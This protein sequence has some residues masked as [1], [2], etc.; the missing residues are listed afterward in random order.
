MPWPH[1]IE[2][3]LLLLLAFCLG[4]LLTQSLRRWLRSRARPAPLPVPAAASSTA[5]QVLLT[6]E[7]PAAPGD[8]KDA[9]AQT[10]EAPSSISSVS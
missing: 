2:T 10:L 1:L 9:Q 8:E 3:A 5:V 4:F 7:G 6:E